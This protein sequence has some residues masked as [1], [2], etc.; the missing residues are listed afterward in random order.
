[1]VKVNDNDSRFFSVAGKLQITTLFLLPGEAVVFSE[2]KTR[3]FHRYEKLVIMSMFFMNA[4]I[5]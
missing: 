1:M 2:Q 5:Q 4:D 3:A